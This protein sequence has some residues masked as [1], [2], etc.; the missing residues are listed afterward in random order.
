MKRKAVERAHV[1][2]T[3]ILE[4]NGIPRVAKA[5]GIGIVRVCCRTMT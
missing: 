1:S 2:I 5:F 3:K 4:R